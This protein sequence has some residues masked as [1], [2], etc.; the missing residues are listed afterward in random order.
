MEIQKPTALNKVK[1]TMS[2]IQSKATWHMK[3]EIQ[4]ITTGKINQL[5][6]TQ[7]WHMIKLIDKDIKT[8]IMT[9]F[10]MWGVEERLNMLNKRWK[11]LK[12]RAQ[13]LSW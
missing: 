3:K 9:I 4:S 7:K 10:H 1:F 2:G 6:L 11:I 13:G 12:R 5:K 8:V